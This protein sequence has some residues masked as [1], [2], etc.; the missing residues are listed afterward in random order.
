MKCQWN[1][2][3]ADFPI[4][5]NEN[6]LVSDE[7]WYQRL[8]HP[9]DLIMIKLRIYTNKKCEDADDDDQWRGAIDREISAHEKH[10]TWEPAY[11]PSVKQAIDTRWVFTIKQDGTEKARLVAKGFQT[12]PSNEVYSPVVRHYNIDNLCPTGEMGNQTTLDIPTAFLNGDL[13]LDIYIKIP[14]GIKC[15]KENV[16]KLRKAL[17]GSREAPRKWNE[18]FII[19]AEQHGIK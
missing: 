11:L 5:P 1:L 12:E 16:L 9:C 18:K 2:F 3:A 6:A 7:M 10:G 15:T 4:Y 17:Y 19:F 8:G 13:D 14:D